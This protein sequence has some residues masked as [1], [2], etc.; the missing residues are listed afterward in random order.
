MKLSRILYAVI[1]VTALGLA[2]T[3]YYQYQLK[4]REI[5]QYQDLAQA[6]SETLARVSEKLLQNRE[7]LAKSWQEMGRL[8]LAITAL[9]K[10]KT[11]FKGELQ[12]LKEEREGLKTKM[13]GLLKEREGLLKERDDLHE[14]FISLE[15]KFHSVEELKKAIRVALIERHQKNRLTKIEMLKT[16]DKVA[17]E[18]GNRGYL[19]KGGRPTFRPTRIRVELEPAHKWSHKETE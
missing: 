17:L 10:E 19:V 13:A 16:M 6:S 15:K 18:Q 14:K 5:S 3:F 1:L 2:F 9:E 8:N 7:E 12:A 11:E 4:D